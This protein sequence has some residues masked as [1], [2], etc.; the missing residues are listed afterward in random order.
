[1]CS[2]VTIGAM[3]LSFSKQ[4]LSSIRKQE[5]LR[6]GE[7]VGVAVSG[8]AD[9][10]AMLRVLLE[11][12]TEIGIVLSVVHFNH[13]L[14]GKASD[15]DEAFVA[16]LAEKFGLTLHMG[17]TDVTKKAIQEKRNLEDAARRARYEFFRRLTKSGLVDVVATA[18]TMDDQAETVLAHILRGTGLAGLAGIHPVTKDG[19]I[20]PMLEAR[21]GDLRRYLRASKQSWREDAT[22]KDTS[23]QRA[24]MRKKLLPLLAKEF[25]PRALEHLA[26]LAGLARQDDSLLNG[27]AEAC[28]REFSRRTGDSKQ[29]EA[30]KLLWPLAGK[31]SYAESAENV[32]HIEKKKSQTQTPA[33]SARMVRALVEEF[34]QAGNEITAGHVEAV[35][36]LAESGEN[37]K[38]L[39]LP[40]GIDV[41]R[42]DDCLFFLRREA[43]GGKKKAPVAFSYPVA[44]PSGGN[45]KVAI[46]EIGCVIRFRS[47]DWP[48][49]Q[50]ETI[51]K[52]W[53]ALDRDKLPDL[54]TLRSLQPGDRM[55]PAGHRGEHKLKRLL[56]EKRI[57][58]WQ[59]EGWPVLENGKNIVWARGFVAAGFAATRETRNAILVSEEKA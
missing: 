36:R 4:A 35:L 16:G 12:R 22:N 49:A 21:R 55:S 46:K 24:R 59:R 54:L 18:H 58:Q 14:R 41:R 3:A 40:G 32:E 7:R 34:K 23:R 5:L 52:G 39:Q 51:E 9:S 38:V 2:R 47:I 11:L 29:I 27:L 26:A 6:A 48:D 53:A 37:G 42:H 44:L 31:V 50:R 19:I 20:R 15:K 25:N 43:R 1:V 56:N 30:A 57:S 45:V 33:L 10:V 17:R 8:G 28:C 13:K